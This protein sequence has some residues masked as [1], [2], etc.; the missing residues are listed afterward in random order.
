M[1]P[2]M[3]SIRRPAG[4]VMSIS[5]VTLANPTLA[6][7]SFCKDW[8]CTAFLRAQRSIMWT[9]TRS[10][11]PFPASAKRLIS[12]GLFSIL[13]KWAETPSSA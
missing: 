7:P 6:S 5:S 8:A 12:L 3:V 11:S 2:I 4:V 13:S 1:P 9:R 10:K